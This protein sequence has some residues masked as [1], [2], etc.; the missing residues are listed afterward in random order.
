MHPSSAAETIKAGSVCTKVNQ[1]KVVGNLTFKC[2]KTGKK[3]IWTKV[4]KVKKPLTQTP[5]IPTTTM[6]GESL[7]TQTPGSTS[8]ASISPPTG[9]ITVYSGA[10]PTS[11]KIL[12]QSFEVKAPLAVANSSSNLKLWIYD[13][14]NSSAPLNSPG[15][16]IQKDGGS[17]NFVGKNRSDGGFD[18]RL[19]TGRYLIDVVEPNG[20]QSKYERGRYMV[21]VDSSGKISINGMLPNSTGYFTVTAVLKNPPVASKTSYQPANSCQLSDKTG[22]TNM[23]NGFPRAEGRLPNRGVVKALII[24]VEFTDVKGSGSPAQ[25]YQEMAKGTAD[26]FYKQSQQTVKFEFTTLSEYLNLKVPVNFFKMGSYN[27]GDPFSFLQAGLQAAE[28]LIDISDFDIAYVLPPS[29]VRPD[30]I[31]YGPAFPAQV[32]SNNYENATG[33]VL[34]AVTGGADAWQNL[35]GAGWKWMAHE[36]GHTFGLYDWYT[37]DGTNPYGP[38][39]LMSNNWSIEAIELNAWNRYITGWLSDSQVR[40]LES[41]QVSSSPKTFTVEAIGADTSKLKSVMIRINESRIMVIEARATAG[42]DKLEAN[43]TGILI[44]V[45]DTSVQTIKGIAKTYSRPNVNASLRDAPLKPGESITVE[46]IT[47]RAGPVTGQDFEITISK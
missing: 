3:L 10:K 27:G 34:N 6:A 29:T 26:F 4:G 12:K 35:S 22:S 21:S 17:W 11:N 15:L 20:N 47:L 38:W 42:L 1:A 2:T 7:P 39:D 28:N 14:E 45:V 9:V 46:G 24:P 8:G 18:T 37:L 41:N 40:C 36:T 25:I 5:T 23:S 13:P 33:R 32:N 16:F 31:A 44:Y 30:Q 19:E 43:Q